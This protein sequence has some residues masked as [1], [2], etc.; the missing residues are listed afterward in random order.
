MRLG[1]CD[2]RVTCDCRDR[3]VQC[4]VNTDYEAAQVDMVL[5]SLLH[6]HD[7]LCKPCQK[8]GVIFSHLAQTSSPY[9]PAMLLVHHLPRRLPAAYRLALAECARRAAWREMYAAQASRLAEHCGRITAKEA[10]KREAV[11]RWGGG[12]TCQPLWGGCTC[13][14]L[15]VCVGGCTCQPLCVGGGGWVHYGEAWVGGSQQVGAADTGSA[16]RGSKGLS[17]KQGAAVQHM[18]AQM[19]LCDFKALRSVMLRKLSYCCR[20]TH[21]HQ[22]AHSHTCTQSLTRAPPPP[23]VCPPAGSWSVT[24]LMTC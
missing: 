16:V 15:C 12:C 13:Q 19:A 6:A 22:F 1:L 8:V 11:N 4:P 3:G 7:A 5:T 24:C 18:S 14:P 10:A 17:S 2:C 21:V 20:V 9:A 23:P